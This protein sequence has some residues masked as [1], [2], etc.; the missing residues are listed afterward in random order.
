MSQKQAELINRNYIRPA[1]LVL[2][3]AKRNDQEYTNQ[4]QYKCIIYTY[5][6]YKS[7]KENEGFFPQTW[8]QRDSEVSINESFALFPE[9]VN[10]QLGVIIRILSRHLAYQKVYWTNYI[11]GQ[12]KLYQYKKAVYRYYPTTSYIF[13]RQQELK[14]EV[15]Q[16][17]GQQRDLIGYI[18]PNIIF[19]MQPK[20]IIYNAYL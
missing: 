15:S 19:A 8:L 3:N 17:R 1:R 2:K 9:N 4:E 7:E 11:I 16:P 20:D 6:K 18:N 13:I 12:Y 14:D 10:H 5:T